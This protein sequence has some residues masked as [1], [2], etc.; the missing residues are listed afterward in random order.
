MNA[1]TTAVPKDLRQTADRYLL[2]ERGRERNADPADV[3]RI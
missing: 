3:G 1:V 2:P